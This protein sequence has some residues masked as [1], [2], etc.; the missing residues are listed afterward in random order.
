MLGGFIEQGEIGVGLA[1]LSVCDIALQNL[2]DV[3]E[4]QKLDEVGR[5]S[6]L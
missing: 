5:R 1:E 6:C 2:V 4:M 3:F